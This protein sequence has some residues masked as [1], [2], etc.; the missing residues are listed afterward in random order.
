MA[1]V[2]EELSLERGDH[3]GSAGTEVVGGIDIDIASVF[4]QLRGELL[5]ESLRFW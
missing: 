4:A 1:P 3:I 5:R 2:L